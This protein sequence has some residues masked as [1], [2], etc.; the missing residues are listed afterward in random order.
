MTV[1]SACSASLV[2]VDVACRYLD[3]Y[4]ADGMLVAGASLW[5]TPEHNEEIGMMRMTQSAT[6][7]CHSFDAKAD[8][9]AKAE[10]MN[11][12]YLKRLDDAIRDG[13]PIRAIIRGT[14]TNS[15]GR[16]PGIASPSAKAQSA[17]IK[18]AYSNAGIKNYNDTQYLEC[19]GTG[20]PAGDPIEVRGAAS[21]FAGTRELGQDLV[22]GSIKSNIG[23]S[24]AAAGLSG[25]MKTVLALEHGTIPGNPTF[26]T[27]NPDI[28]FVASRV[29]VT[30]TPIKWPATTLAVRRASVNSFGFGGSNAHAILENSQITG[31]ISS[32]KQITSDFFSDDDEDE[33]TAAIDA[34]SKVLV[35]SANDQGSLKSYIQSLSGHLI[36][37]AVSVDIDDLVYTLSERRSHH[38][39]RAY[40]VTKSS[41]IDQD[42]LVFGQTAGSQPRIGFVFTGQGAQWSQMGL[43]LVKSL[44][45][46]KEVIQD[47]DRALQ[48]LP[49]PPEW[50]LLSELTEE[51]SAEAL[52]QPEFSQ[53]LVTAL[54]L[55][56]LEVLKDWGIN[57]QAVVGHSSGEIAAAAAA[58]LITPGEAIK[59]AYYR[60]QGAKRFPPTEPLGMLAVGV[61]VETVQEYLKSSE[62]K[63]QIACYN[64]PTSLTMS[65]TASALAELQKRLQLD[66]HFAR[67]LLVDLA[68]HS[69][70]MAPIGEVYEKMLLDTLE[71]SPNK[72]S[73][74]MY[75][76]VTGKV[77]KGSPDAAYWKS[78]MVSPVR[79]NQATK[80]LLQQPQGADFLIEI[81]PSNAL[82]GPIA[83][84]KKSL[85]G[86]PADATYTSALKRG[87]ESVLALYDVAGQLFLAGG[88]VNLGKV[89]RVYESKKPSVIVDL[90]NYVWNHSQRYWHE[91]QA[92]KD[93]RFKK[94]IYHDL[95]GS[96]MNGT[97]WQAP[98][99]Q[100]TL[101]LADMPWL[102]DHQMG[103][104]IIFPGAGY[105]AMA[106]EAVYQ[107]SMVTKWDE[108]EPE[109]YRYRFKDIRF[110]RA[111]V[112]EEDEAATYTLALTPARGGSTREWYEFRVCSTKDTVYTEHCAGLVC[113]ETDYKETPPPPGAL[114]P[115]QLATPASM[116]YK[117]VKESGYNYGP[118]FQKHL[119]FEATM[120]KTESRSTVS[121]EPPP[122]KYG[123]S[124]YPVHPASIDACFY[125]GILAISKGDIPLVGAVHVPQILSSL[126]IPARKEQ[127]A[128]A[129]ALTS[130]RFLGI[131][132]EDLHRNYGSDLSLHD[133]KDG[134]LLFEMKGLT[135][136][137]IETSE[138]EGAKH[139]FTRLAWE[140][141]LPLLLSS[142]EPKLR[143]FLKE[144]AKTTQDLID[145]IAHKLPTL[146][147]LEIN[148]NPNDTS[149]L[150]VQ[151]EP[152]LIRAASSQYHFAVSDPSTLVS[153]Q[154]LH[155]PNATSATFGLLD[156]TQ[157]EAVV[158]DVK[159]DLTILKSSEPVEDAI[160]DTVSKSLSKS[161]RAGSIVLGIGNGISLE[162][163]GKT[164]A[165]G[166]DVYI[167]QVKLEAISDTTF[168][169]VSYVS[170]LDTEYDASSCI[171][172]ELES[173]GWKVQK[174]VD[175]ATDITPGQLVVVLDELFETIMNRPSEK[176]WQILKTLIQKQIKILWVTSGAHIDVNNPTSAAITG[177]FRTVRA[178]EGV[179]VNTLDVEHPQGEATPGAIAS[180]LALLRQPEPENK[181]ENEFVER[182]GILQISRLV[183]NWDL[184]KLQ[185]HH[186]SDRKTEVLDIHSSDTIIQMGA[187]R[188]GDLDSIHYHEISPEPIPLQD[189][190]VEIEVYA[191]GLNY[192]DV[193]VTMGIV[194]GDERE[195][196][197]EAAGIVT[198][199]SPSVTSLKV[200]QRVVVFTPATIANRVHT[201]PGRVHPLPDWMSFEEAATLCGVYLTSI[202]SLFDMADITPGK[203][204]LIHSAAGGVGISSLQLAQYAGA[205]VR[206][207]NPSF[208]VYL[209]LLSRSLQPWDLPTNGTSS[210]LPLAS[211][212]TIYS[213]P[214]TLISEIRFWPLLVAEEWMLCSILLL[215]ICWMNLSASWLTGESWSR[216]GR[217]IFLI[218]T[219]LL[220][221]NLT[222]TS[223]S[224]PLTCPIRELQTISSLGKSSPLPCSTIE[225]CPY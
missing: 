42:K 60:G 156:V 135:T 116:I 132:R 114:E 209:T 172:G 22:I 134:S 125:I 120:G 110:L 150:W 7:R 105:C 186:P 36:N 32:Y 97:A 27:P 82:S 123:Q 28:D 93:W 98:I 181:K 2:G 55:A 21:V 144:S 211:L 11:V 40:A 188:L 101:K 6:G 161:V 167:S 221:S 169:T 112:L 100:K 131:G 183:P 197:G 80:E 223:L 35:L 193:V 118:C 96:K 187:E 90:P 77:L 50:S 59:I 108:K 33:E 204:V 4:Q 195:L 208:S 102:R 160:Q 52:R 129:I 46:A 180:C 166:E 83:Q 128:E 182:G 104:Q 158:A 65:G 205:E 92:S 67:M 54:Q 220:W 1:D 53:P 63:I 85:S 10:G 109:R 119:L 38:Y 133:P 174:V 179:R 72:P 213:I 34:A 202:Y 147:V 157:S 121:M 48:S 126:V 75:S 113:V 43:S 196:G 210:N 200:G 203:R 146:K 70:Y 140:A 198:K 192:K 178:E 69:D 89:N 207:I 26:I 45:L 130:A 154:G 3:S 73:A 13:D 84:I 194:P 16:T 64:S 212:M 122:S 31:H 201:R 152:S 29:R 99:F 159:F 107:T 47:L 219:A 25:L 78:N 185:G 153:A 224:R 214:E 124:F 139:L 106:V 9:Y 76:S 136:R 164:Q 74:R 94:F 127:P 175:P 149:S 8:G 62:N 87:A 15:D 117:A 115:L 88:S 86:A 141:D 163:L 148:L 138:E 222:V 61:S 71:P 151:D 95:L 49:D 184:T 66:G 168:P 79:F 137:D 24:E 37:P 189:G 162:K 20:T 206:T 103:N 190:Y 81:G 177:F 12:V 142:P 56:I 91:T 171:L 218:A 18:A 23:H 39:Y 68:Y 191:A 111:L 170:L 155:S 14:A 58:G 176:Q 225:R 143:Q 57:P 215:V 145:L 30:R 199:V 17:A 19:H 41:S 51:R 173:L 5:L 44:P 165:L 216:S 217:R